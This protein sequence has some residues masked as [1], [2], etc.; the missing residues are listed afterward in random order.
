[1]YSTV[2]LRLCSSF[3]WIQILF[4]FKPVQSFTD[5]QAE[6][7]SAVFSED[8]LPSILWG[9]AS[10]SDAESTEMH[11][12]QKHILLNYLAISESSHGC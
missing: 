1:M 8:I 10:S 2:C 3:A 5:P 4:Q 7:D 12:R 6:V 11:M 9:S